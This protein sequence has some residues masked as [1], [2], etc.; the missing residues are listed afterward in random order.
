MTEFWA[1]LIPKRV[2]RRILLKTRG[3]LPLSDSKAKREHVQRWLKAV[4]VCE[5]ESGFICNEA[6]RMH[7]GLV[8]EL[9]PVN[10]RLQIRA[11][12]RNW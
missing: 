2:P 4:A 8:D 1:V 6:E 10:S 9:R 11:P 3:Q 5:C 12:K 7:Q